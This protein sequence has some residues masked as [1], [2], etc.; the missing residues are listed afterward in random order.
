MS[1]PEQTNSDEVR[2]IIQEEFMQEERE[3]IHAIESWRMKIIP[4]DQTEP[5]PDVQSIRSQPDPGAA[6]GNGDGHGEQGQILIRHV[7]GVPIDKGL[8]VG[9]AKRGA[10]VHLAWPAG[11]D[12]YTL[13]VHEIDSSDE[14]DPNRWKP[15]DR[16]DVRWEFDDDGV[17]RDT[18]PAWLEACTDKQF[19]E[20]ATAMMKA[21]YRSAI[22]LDE[23]EC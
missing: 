16:A 22:W 5:D 21:H 13:G 12:H 20:W 9:V 14:V 2:S 15:V 8:Y 3:G 6:E 10:A 19:R 4:S 18:N 11:H 23:M 1:S 7:R 17:A